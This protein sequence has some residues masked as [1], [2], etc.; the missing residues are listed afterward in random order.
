MNRQF[1][2]CI[3]YLLW[4]GGIV[5]AAGTPPAPLMIADFEDPGV[6][7]RMTVTKSAS[8]SLSD[9]DVVSGK[10][11]LEVHVGKFSEHGDRWPYV[12]LIDKYFTTPIDLTRYS[13]VV[14]SVR[15]VTEGLATV[16]FYLSSKPYNDGGRNLEGEGFV[17][18]GGSTMECALPTSLFR[19]PMNDPSS[20]QALMF[21]FPPNETNAV[22]RIDN[23]RAEYDPAVGSPAEK[24]AAEL[25]TGAS[26]LMKQVQSL[27]RRVNWQAV[28]ADRAAALRQRI[29]QLEQELRSLQQR[30]QVAA[31]E[32]W[33][34]QYNANRDAVGLL[35]RSLGDFALADKAGFHLWQRSRY[36][37]VRRQATPELTT[38]AVERL[39]LKMARNEFR[40]TSFMVTAVDRD[41]ALEVAVAAAEPGLAEAVQIRWSDFVQPKGYEEYGDVLVPM[42]GALT[43]PRGE[44]RELWATFDTRWHDV[45]PGRHELTLVLT[46]RAGAQTRKIPVTLTVWPFALPSYDVLPNNAYVEY[47]NS[48]IASL[49]PEDGVRHMKMYGVN[50]TYVLPNELPWPAQTDGQGHLTGFDG[51]KLTARI[52]LMLTAWQ[53]NPGPE[54]LRWIFSLSGAP[55]HMMADKSL[56][57]LSDPWNRVFAQWLEQFKQLLKSAGLADDDWM[58]VLA[59]EASESKLAGYE[60]PF[61]E[62]IKRLD[63]QI[64][65]TCNASQVIND[66]ALAARFF[67]A[68]DVLQP[69]LDSLKHSPP[70]RDFLGIPRRPLWTYRCSG[71]VGLDKNLYDYYRVYAWDNIRYGIVGTGIWTYCAQGQSAWAESGHSLPYSLVFKHRDKAEVIHSRRYEFYREGADDYRY[72]QAL[73][74]AAKPR[75]AKAERDAQALV[76]EAITDIT[77]D[78]SD[79]TRAEKWRARL[80][81]RILKL[82]R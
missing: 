14:A 45:K 39:E 70:L 65:I 77:S 21:V 68:F 41:V 55:E 15:N 59:D 1:L 16:M 78:P 6:L 24:L 33:K 62:M 26:G 67:R 69:C 27:D 20:V 38:P 10:R 54:R 43:I 37:Y 61:A 34:G 3:A 32:G 4:G 63:P 64:K 12:F 75:G 36:S 60:I 81:E 76:Q 44:S 56:V 74:A 29:P 31:Q 25:A 47:H 13:R 22:Y 79:V 71:M 80:A 51:T 18:S 5:M 46:D 11:C 35:A 30:A 66:P 40:D 28:P 17:I 23:I 7:E 42:D 49:V 48:E 52:R 19:R 73:I 72:V 2:L 53:A 57:F 82:R 9:Q 8:V 58:L 50:M